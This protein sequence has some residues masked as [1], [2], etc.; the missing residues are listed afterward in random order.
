M[1]RRRIVADLAIFKR[2][3]ELRIQELR[4]GASAGD[5]VQGI[6]PSA[7]A[8][9]VSVADSRDETNSAQ[10]ES[11]PHAVANA[12]FAHGAGVA[13][14][15]GDVDS[16]LSAS[17]GEQRGRA[18]GSTLSKLTTC[19][20]HP[21][22][23]PQLARSKLALPSSSVASTHKLVG[24]IVR[25]GARL[26]AARNRFLVGFKMNSARL[27]LLKAVL[28]APVPL[29]V[30]GHARVMGVSRQTARRTA[31]HLQT[32]GL[33]EFTGNFRN[34]KAPIIMLTP[35]G[36]MRLEELMRAERR[37]VADLA[38]GFDGLTRAKTAWL[39]RLIRERTGS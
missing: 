35:L 23:C 9:S 18:T 4:A 6:R 16:R 30:A 2:L 3:E 11:P 5:L 19:C 20:Q 26:T 34:E 10:R 7:E 33:L 12:T 14:S 27:R 1:T 37:W 24:E 15:L 32:E 25:T 22:G 29:T 39:L 28:R 13:G 17:T 38:R 36:S 8:I 31:R 21:T